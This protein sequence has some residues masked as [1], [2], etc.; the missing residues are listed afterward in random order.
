MIGDVMV[1]KNNASSVDPEIH[2]IGLVYDVLKSRQTDAQIR[3]VQY[4]CQKLGIH[5]DV[6]PSTPERATLGQHVAPVEPDSSVD[7][8]ESRSSSVENANDLSGGISPVAQKWIKRSGL[9][10]ERLSH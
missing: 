3:V 1:T 10:I 4:V 2:A 6:W 8:A 9:D 5:S 7:Q